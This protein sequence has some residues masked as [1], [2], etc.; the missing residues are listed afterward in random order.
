MLTAKELAMF[1]A[2]GH[3]IKQSTLY[4]VAY[5]TIAMEVFCRDDLCLSDPAVASLKRCLKAFKDGKPQRGTKEFAGLIDLKEVINK[6]I[7]T[8]CRQAFFPPGN[9]LVKSLE[10]RP[11][12]SESLKV[13]VDW[14]EHTT[15]HV[16]Y[17]RFKPAIEIPYNDTKFKVTMIND[18]SISCIEKGII[19][20]YEVISSF[21]SDIL[22][23]HSSHKKVKYNT[24]VK[25]LKT[26]LNKY[27]EELPHANS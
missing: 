20:N 9:I 3:D 13:F 27:K 12:K 8:F 2:L 4:P 17:T 6:Y 7:Y 25:R 26:I 10:V 16:G 15:Q 19:F 21:R 11:L 23:L 1:K 14:P 18:Y 5:N 24:F 22:K